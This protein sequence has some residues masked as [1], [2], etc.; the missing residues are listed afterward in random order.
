[1]WACA[2]LSLVSKGEV[3][4]P[5]PTEEVLE[6]EGPVHQ[7]GQTESRGEE[8]YGVTPQILLTSGDASRGHARRQ[9]AVSTE[10]P[11]ASWTVMVQVDRYSTCGQI[12]CMWAG[13]AQVDR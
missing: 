6:G 10:M 13:K 12:W 11:Q 8:Q 1:M 5:P 2:G 4:G 7:P 9:Q 3:V